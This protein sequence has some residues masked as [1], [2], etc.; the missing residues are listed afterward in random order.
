MLTESERKKLIEDFLGGIMNSEALSTFTDMLKHDSKL[1]HELERESGVDA[2]LHGT[3]SASIADQYFSNALNSAI[4]KQV[5]INT[6]KKGFSLNWM[7]IYALAASMLLALAGVYIASLHKTS[8]IKELFSV[9][10]HE[11]SMNVAFN[12]GKSIYRLS[13]GSLFLSEEGSKLRVLHGDNSAINVVLS[14]G[15]VCFEMSKS[16][17]NTI[18][19]A[20]PHAAIIL[21]NRNIT[22]IVVTELETEIAVL[23]GNAEVVHRFHRD[24][25]KE[26]AAGGTVFAGFDAVQVVQSIAPEICENRTN[27]FKAYISWVQKQ[28][29]G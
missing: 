13:N 27:M 14:Q 15:N 1:R 9:N 7:K 10:D 20:T 17:S 12:S 5:S 24:Q 6:V 11:S 25:Q 19:V 2:L 8:M 18:T 4:R 22:R 16:D 26:L 3:A 29:R 28:A 21:S 23:E